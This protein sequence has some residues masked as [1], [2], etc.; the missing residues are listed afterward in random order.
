VFYTKIAIRQV[1]KPQ[2]PSR[3]KQT[4]ARTGS[5]Q[6]PKSTANSGSKTLLRVNGYVP[7]DCA[8][9]KFKAVRGGWG[10]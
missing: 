8:E 6:R 3:L 4:K 1:E 9:E 2:K 10:C 5:S 7:Q